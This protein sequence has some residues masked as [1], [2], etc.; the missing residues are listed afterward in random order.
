MSE[1]KLS[2]VVSAVVDLLTPLSSE[3]RKRAV[4][5]ALMILGD[6]PLLPESIGPREAQHPATESEGEFSFPAQAKSW[7]RQ[8]NITEEELQQVFQIEGGRAEIIV[9]D[10]AGHNDKERTH[11]AYA[12]TGVANLLQTGNASFDDKPA[13]QLCKTA[14]CYNKGNHARY[15]GDIGN[16]MMGTKDKGWTLTAPGKKYAA[17]LI[18]RLGG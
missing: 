17:E 9:S 5:A 3:D 1:V 7:M 14:G 16:L 8:Y 10:F 18:K 15:M 4:S 2:N 6:A 13:R 12:L 11:A